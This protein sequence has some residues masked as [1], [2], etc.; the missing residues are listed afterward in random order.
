MNYQ[1][2]LIM[3]GFCSRKMILV[4]L[5]RTVDLAHSYSN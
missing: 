5:N 1:L 3:V 4:E 2:A